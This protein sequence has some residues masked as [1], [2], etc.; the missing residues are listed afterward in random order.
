M[1]RITTLVKYRSALHG[2]LLDIRDWLQ[3]VGV[4]LYCNVFLGCLPQ[5]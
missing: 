1:I 5:A 4:N 3:R 2:A